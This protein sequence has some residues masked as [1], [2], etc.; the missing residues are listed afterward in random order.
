MVV[1]HAPAEGEEVMITPSAGDTWTG[2]GSYDGPTPYIVMG[3]VWL[4]SLSAF[5]MVVA[6][7][8]SAP[9]FFV[10]TLFLL[11]FGPFALLSYYLYEFIT[12]DI[13]TWRFHRKSRQNAEKMT[14]AEQRGLLED[15]KEILRLLEGQPAYGLVSALLERLAAERKAHKDTASRMR[16]ENERLRHSQFGKAWISRKVP[17]GDAEGVG[18]E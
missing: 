16:A 14:A 7:A 18:D 17:S 15:E 12:D 6:Y 5:P 1:G 11:W 4:L 13:S 3:F 10:A 2:G 9:S 8:F